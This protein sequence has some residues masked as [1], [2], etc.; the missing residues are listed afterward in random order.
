ML[1]H[2]WI[3]GTMFMLFGLEFHVSTAISDDADYDEFD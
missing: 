2:I 1:L 3:Y